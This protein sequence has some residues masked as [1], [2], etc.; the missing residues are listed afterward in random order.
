MLPLKVRTLFTEVVTHRRREHQT[1]RDEAIQ[2]FTFK[3]AR[4]GI[5][6][7]SAFNDGKVKIYCEAFQKYAAGVWDDMQRV[8]GG[9]FEV[10]PGCEDDL[11]NFLKESLAALY[12]ADT[13][14]LFAIKNDVH[15]PT[16]RHLARC[17]PRFEFRCRAVTEKLTTEI[18]IFVNQLRAMKQKE[19][20]LVTIE[21]QKR[22]VTG[23]D[24]QR[25]LVLA[26]GKRYTFERLNYKPSGQPPDEPDGDIF[27][28]PL[29][30][31]VR[32]QQWQGD[33]KWN[34]EPLTLTKWMESELQNLCDNRAIPRN[35]RTEIVKIRALLRVKQGELH[36]HYMTR[37]IVYSRLKHLPDAIREQ[38]NGVAWFEHD[39]GAGGWNTPILLKSFR[40]IIS[41]IQSPAKPAEQ[42]NPPEITDTFLWHVQQRIL[43][44]LDDK[45]RSAPSAS[46]VFVC[47]C[48]DKLTLAKMHRGNRNWSES[49]IKLRIKLLRAFLKKEFNG[50]KLESFFVDRSIFSA[51][52][53]QFADYRAKKI[54]P[55]S[56]G[57]LHGGDNE[58]Q[59]D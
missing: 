5:S 30:E 12:E 7:S 32:L 41:G 54:S 17:K 56:A 35:Q 47:F 22:K 2:E 1:E 14:S 33:W 27:G 36:L 13:K 23:F 37:E 11:I 58:D 21:G 43:D 45:L 19:A 18:K 51:A 48:R 53:R 57:E 16:A 3:M 50:L 40:E 31:A 34:D 4:Q 42:F 55:N 25:N 49:T 20:S 38:V 28:W 8:L 6:Q 10:Y 52:E 29:L 24:E 15:T 9:G 26:D 59:G 46:Q 39:D 44:K